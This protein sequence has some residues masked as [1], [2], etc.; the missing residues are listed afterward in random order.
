LRK[1]RT[2]VDLVEEAIK[3][4]KNLSISYNANNVAIPREKQKS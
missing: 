2:I 1:K 3:R 4:E